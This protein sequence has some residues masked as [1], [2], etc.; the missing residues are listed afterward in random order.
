MFFPF[1]F[2]S[3]SLLS[4]FAPPQTTPQP[5]APTKVPVDVNTTFQKLEATRVTVHR[6]GI[7][8]PELL[9]QWSKPELVLLASAVFRDQRVTLHTKNR[10]LRSVLESLAELLGGS[11]RIQDAGKTLFLDTGIER[12]SYA[13][14]WWGYYL[15]ERK[16]AQ[17]TKFEALKAMLNRPPTVYKPGVNFRGEQRFADERTRNSRFFSLLSPE[18]KQQIAT[19]ALTEDYSDILGSLGEGETVLVP[20]ESL[21]KEARALLMEAEPGLRHAKEPSMF[22]FYLSGDT[23]NVKQIVP[24]QISQVLD[25]SSDYAMTMESFTTDFD[26]RM[27]AKVSTQM[28]HGIPKNWQRLLRYQNKTIWKNEP[29]KKYD[30]YILMNS[31]TSELLKSLTE[32]KQEDVLADSY[33]ERNRSPTSEE[34][35]LSWKSIPTEAL[36]NQLAAESDYSWMRRPD[37]LY[38]VRNNRWYRDDM[39]QVPVALMTE[40]R[41][42]LEQETI[43]RKG[44]KKETEEEKAARILDWGTRFLADLSVFQI[45]YGLRCS[46][47]E[48]QGGGGYDYRSA[49]YEMTPF[50]EYA[51]AT[52]RNYRLLR[53]YSLLNENQKVAFRRGNLPLAQLSPAQWVKAESLLLTTSA[54]KEELA[55]SVLSLVPVQEI[56]SSFYGYV[57][58]PMMLPQLSLKTTFVPRTAN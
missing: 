27:V 47:D 31:P 53:F 55:Q 1:A 29:P 25:V 28:T 16:Q 8:L 30:I 24:G 43:E 57:K 33:A 48:R 44:K 19:L 9:K 58:Y 49:D 12:K 20:E 21:S 26:Q 39:T 32:Q 14:G 11:W 22:G 34:T 17:Q 37:K 10:S 5:S 6:A 7:P 41:K 13:Q 15:A 38:L 50:S 2:L 45:A 23:V 18:I 40:W 56:I 46:L 4:G 51:E 3:C 54:N 52:L 42:R 36:L 35:R